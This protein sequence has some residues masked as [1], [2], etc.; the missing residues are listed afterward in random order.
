MQLKKIEEFVENLWLS[1]LSPIAK[2]LLFPHHEMTIKVCMLGKLTIRFPLMVKNNEWVT[3]FKK[4][5][6]I[7]LMLTFMANK[8]TVSLLLPINNRLSIILE[9][10]DK[11]VGVSSVEK[12]NS[13]KIQ[14]VNSLFTILKYP[15]NIT[16]S[17][18]DKPHLS[19]NSFTL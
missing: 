12:L 9:T 17:K 11:K 3:S 18:L 15:I 13:P 2:W 19:L 14:V 1:S 8:K 5:R 4:N 16:T 7:K 10:L 6:E